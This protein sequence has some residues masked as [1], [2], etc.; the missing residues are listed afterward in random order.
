MVELSK[1]IKESERLR[2]QIE[3][4]R[5]PALRREM[6]KTY[7]HYRHQWRASSLR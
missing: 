1:L 6:K 5:D 7:K 2:P 3:A 4:E